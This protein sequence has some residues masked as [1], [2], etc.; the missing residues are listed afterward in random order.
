MGVERTNLIVTGKDGE[1]DDTTS[2]DLDRLFVGLQNV[3]KIVLHF[4]GGL[5]SKDAGLG[6][7]ARLWDYYDGAGAYPVFFVWE[8]SL[9]ETVTHNLREIAGEDIFKILLKYVLKFSAGK[10]GQAEGARSIT[11]VMP[12]DMQMHIEL[13]RPDEPFKEMTPPPVVQPLTAGEEDEFRDQLDRDTDF[14]ETVQAIADATLPETQEIGVKGFV[15]VRKSAR[16]LMSPEIVDEI[17]HDAT[18]NGRKGLLSTAAMIGRAVKVLTN[19]IRRFHQKRD[20]GLYPTVFEEILREFYVANIGERVWRAMKRE[21]ADTFEAHEGKPVR[22]GRV[23][24]DR[25]ESMLKSGRRPEITLVGHSTGAVF[26]DNVIEE[27][28]RRQTT[29]SMPADF[30][31]KNVIFLAPAATCDN[32]AGVLGK[33]L[34]YDRFRLFGMTDAYEKNDHML[35]FVYPRSLLYFVSG[36]LEQEPD[37]SNAVDMPIL[38][39]QRYDLTGDVYT[40]PSVVACRQYLGQQDFAVW[41]PSDG[42]DGLRSQSQHH[43]DFDNDDPTLKSVQF[44]IKN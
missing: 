15:R 37:G 44:M 3:N 4:H 34:L 35:S 39:M 33:A 26:I 24:L 21:T 8:S 40:M 31:F 27:V 12:N 17:K 10:L 30:K 25:L 2:D 1:L 6:I 5:V 38:G 9:I 16:T 36:I 28:Q 14:Q 22:G 20:H 13:S 19:V 32:F 42:G 23:F 41:S 43:G 29:G 7:A 11:A 18:A